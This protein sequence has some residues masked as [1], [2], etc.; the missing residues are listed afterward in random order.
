MAQGFSDDAAIRAY[1][2]ALEEALVTS[3]SSYLRLHTSVSPTTNRI[4][5]SSGIRSSGM[6]GFS[7]EGI[8]AEWDM[9]IG[10][11]YGYRWWKLTVPASLCGWEEAAGGPIS[12]RL[13]GANN[14][15]WGSGR[16]EAECTSSAPY[17]GW[18]DLLAGRPP[19][20]HEPPEYRK[21]CGCGFWAYFDPMLQVDAVL[22]GMSGQIPVRHRGEAQI[23]V[24]G[25]VRGTGRVIIGEK[26]FRSQYAEIVGLCVADAAKD[27]LKWTFSTIGRY[28]EPSRPDDRM[29]VLRSALRGSMWGT[30]YASGGRVSNGTEYV[31]PAGEATR[32]FRFAT[33]ETILAESY[34]GAK[35]FCD[36]DDMVKYF[37]PDS[38][39]APRTA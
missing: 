9:A 32:L 14:Q 26:G 23:P 13:T 22:G 36:Q 31:A 19:L 11:V 33:V 16:Q 21:P 1:I 20:R 3:A 27:M 10:E 38:N 2:K 29:S 6:Q 8:P 4:A 25:V 37:P 24:F 5:V 18:D 15:S 35:I 12:G 30:P 28:S 7:E 17:P 34:P 39:Y